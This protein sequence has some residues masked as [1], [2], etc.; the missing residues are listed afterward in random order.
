MF[1]DEARQGKNLGGRNTLGNLMLC[2]VSAFLW[3]LEVSIS[4]HRL[5]CELGFLKYDAANVSKDVF[6]SPTPAHNSNPSPHEKNQTHSIARAPKGDQTN[7]SSPLPLQN[8]PSNRDANQSANTNPGEASRKVPPII[9]SPTKLA[10]ADGAKRDVASGREAKQ[11][12]EDYNQAFR[13]WRG[14]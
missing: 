8:F 4:S 2:D 10:S 14:P 7:I 13:G 3:G 1:G 11:Q 12:G 9:L 5:S 6:S